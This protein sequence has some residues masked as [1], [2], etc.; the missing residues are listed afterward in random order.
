MLL[1]C[2]RH[3][4]HDSLDESK[5]DWVRDRERCFPTSLL[6]KHGVSAFL[7]TVLEKPH[8]HSQQEAFPLNSISLWRSLY[9]LGY[10]FSRH[11]GR[12]DAIRLTAQEQ[13]QMNAEMLG[14]SSCPSVTQTIWLYERANST[15][16]KVSHWCD[17]NVCCRTRLMERNGERWRNGKRKTAA[18]EVWLTSGADVELKRSAVSHG[19]QSTEKPESCRQTL[20]M[21]AL[22]RLSC[23]CG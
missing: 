1:K 11:A 18:S 7:D 17:M 2:W 3:S 6:Q 15:D 8:T 20:A 14:S 5:R 19:R 10:G 22:Q 12:L 21:E 9:R 16:H 23:G 13:T 4:F